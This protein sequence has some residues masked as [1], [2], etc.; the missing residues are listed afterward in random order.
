MVYIPTKEQL[1]D[2]FTNPIPRNQV[3]ILRDGI[4]LKEVKNG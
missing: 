2:L 3:E 1:G 4:G